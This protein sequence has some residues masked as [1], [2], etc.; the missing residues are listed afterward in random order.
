MQL[1]WREN[2]PGLTRLEMLVIVAFAL[3]AL[4]LIVMGIARTRQAALREQC[5]NNLRVL[6]ESIRAYSDASA[7]DKARQ[8]LPAARIADGYATW[9][10]L[11]APYLSEDHALLQWD[12]ET[13]YFQQTDAVRQ[14]AYVKFICPARRREDLLSIS[15]DIDKA[16]KEFSGA[17]GD[18][19]CVAGDGSKEHDWTGPDANGAIILAKVLERKGDRILKWESR[20]SYASLTRGESYTLLIGEKH[21]PIGHLGEAQAGD[22][23]IYNGALPANFSRVGGPGFPLAREIDAPVNNN[24]GSWHPGV[25]QFLMA[26]NSVN[27]MAVDISESV[28]GKLARRG[29]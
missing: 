5:K 10:V 13:T 9:P 18:Y 27:V 8:R 29:E 15:G 16:G 20:T 25:C 12:K 22:G 3:G 19:A 23:S 7:A 1:Q 14:A 2:R 11:L 6:G 24:F 26:D 21:V 17:V 4:G 28:L